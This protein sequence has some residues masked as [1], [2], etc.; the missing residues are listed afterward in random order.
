MQAE[1]LQHWLGQ[2]IRRGGGARVVET[3]ER[4]H[5]TFARRFYAIDGPVLVADVLDGRDGAWVNEVGGDRCDADWI[6]RIRRALDLDERVAHLF[7][8]LC[9]LSNAT[10]DTR[11]VNYPAVDLADTEEFKLFCR[12]PR[13]GDRLGA[14]FLAA[15]LILATGSLGRRVPNDSRRL[16]EVRQLAAAIDAARG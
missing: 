1:E 10:G 15:F 7:G 2:A 13:K 3:V 4:L 12:R 16:D 8:A 6:A 11:F 14:S 9:A 5:G